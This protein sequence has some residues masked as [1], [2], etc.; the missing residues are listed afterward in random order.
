[1]GSKLMLK[2]TSEP[3][4]SILKLFGSGFDDVLTG[5]GGEDINEGGEGGDVAL[6]QE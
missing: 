2:L 1:M 5:E 4:G 3:I 6:A